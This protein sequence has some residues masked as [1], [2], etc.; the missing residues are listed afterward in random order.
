MGS[1]L[2]VI[3]WQPW[4]MVSV[5]TGLMLC[6]GLGFAFGLFYSASRTATIVSVRLS[7]PAASDLVAPAE[8]PGSRSLA[9]AQWIKERAVRQEQQR[10]IF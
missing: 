6:L 9:L 7:M 1:P 3:R 4:A 10:W 8:L 5:I 2:R